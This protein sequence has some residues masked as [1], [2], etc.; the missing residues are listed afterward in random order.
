[1]KLN[2]I[3]WS[4]SL[5]LLCW[6]ANAADDCLLD[7]VPQKVYGS[8]PVNTYFL[9][10]LAPEKMIGLNFPLDKSAVGVL[11]EHL[12][13]LPVVGGWFGQGK[14]PN[15][16]TLLSILPDLVLTTESSHTAGVEKQQAM[17]ADMKLTSCRFKL[18]VL[19]DYPAAYR[20]VGQWLGVAERGTQLA[21]FAQQVIDE[22][23]Q[24][25][26]Q[27]A[28]PVRVYYAQ[29]SDG[30]AS[31]CRGSL[32]AEVI[33]LAGAVN[34]HQ[35]EVTSGFGMV[36]VS[37]EQVLT[38]NPDYI[39]T[40]DKQTYQHIITD[41][42]WQKV[43]AV[44]QGKVLF[45]PGTPWRWMDRPPSFT[46]LLAAPWLMHQLYPTYYSQAQLQYTISTFFDLFFHHS[47]EQQQLEKLLTA[48][49]AAQ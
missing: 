20:Q 2:K 6:Q 25:R 45:M 29:G 49:G 27:I 18:D 30:L 48:Q 44:N 22:L 28:Q 39:V 40:Q 42:K 5:S 21:D 11:P 35:C 46:R 8:S 36:K 33:E 43:A 24:A 12:F 1:M 41:K 37:L 31:E 16:E 10:S 19:S 9:L 47:L 13:Q 15:K 3:L 38:E 14:T 17:L 26:Q 23:A 32:H 4:V 7:S 34:P